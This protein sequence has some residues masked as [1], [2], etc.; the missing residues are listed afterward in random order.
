MGYLKLTLIAGVLC[1]RAPI[2]GLNGVLMADGNSTAAAKQ[3]D[4]TSA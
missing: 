4:T 1:A 3:T 2:Y